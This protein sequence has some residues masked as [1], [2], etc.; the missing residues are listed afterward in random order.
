MVTIEPPP[1]AFRSGSA[2]RAVATS[3]YALTS[4][5]SQKRSRG[6]SVKRPSRSSAA[7]KATEWTRRSSA[8]SNVSATSP[9][10]RATSA[11][12]RTS[13]AV[14]SG[15]DTESASS[16]TDFSIRSP[17]KVNARVAPSSA[18]R[19]AIPHAIER[20][21][22][23]PSTSPRL[24]AKR[25]STSKTLCGRRMRQLPCLSLLRPVLLVLA[26]A[27]A[28]AAA[29][30][31]AAEL[32]PSRYPA[33]APRVRTGRIAIPAAGASGRVEVLVRLPQAPLARW[34]DRTLQ[35]L[36]ARRSKLA[37]RSASS[38]AYIRRLAAAQAAATAQ[39]RQAIPG[40]RVERRF[41]IVLNALAVEL[42]ASR[43]PSLLRLPFVAQVYPSIQYRPTL[44]TSPAIIGATAL[45]AG[46]TLGDGIKIAV[47]DDGIDRG[48]RFFDPSGFAYP[49][50]FPKGNTA[51]TTPKVIVARVFFSRRSGRRDRLPY[52]PSVSF[53]GTHVAGI[54]AGDAGTTAPAGGDHPTVVGLSGVAP[55]ASVGNYRVFTEPTPVGHVGN[56]PQIVAAFEAAV[57]DGM[58]VINFSGGGA[59][60]DPSRDALVTTVNNVAAAGVVPVIAA[61]NDRTDFGLGTVGSPSTADAAISVAA[62]SNT[63]VFGSALQA[64]G[65]DAPPELQ[66]IP[67]QPGVGDNIT[68]GGFE[69]TLV[70]V[71]SI[72]GTDGQPVDPRLCGPPSD[73]NGGRGTIPS[74]SLSGSILLASRGVCTFAS[75]GERASAAGADGLNLMDNRPGEPNVFPFP[76]ASPAAISSDREG[77]H[78]HAFLAAHGGRAT[79][80]L[81]S[82]PRQVDTGR[83]GIITDFSSGGPTP[84]GHRLKP[85][86]A[87]PGGQ[88]LSST[89]PAGGGPFAVFDG[90][91]M[92]TPHVAGAA[93]LLLERHPTW[94]PA[95]IKSALVAT[96]G[97]A[98][99]NTAR[100]VEAPVLLEGSG[101]V[102]LMTADTPLV[103]TAPT[104]LSFAD[105]DASSGA[106]ERSQLVTVTD[107]GGGEGAWQ[108]SV[109]PQAATAGT[110]VDATP[111]VQVAPGGATQVSVAVHVAANAEK[112][113]NYGFVLLSRGGAMRRIPYLVIVTRPA[114]A[115]V[116]AK[117][118][119]RLQRGDTRSGVS[120]ASFYRYPTA[121][122]GP[123]PDYFGPP[124]VEDGA[125]QLYVKRVSSKLVNFGAV[126]TPLSNTSLP[127]PWVL[128]SRDEF[129]VQ[130]YTGTPVNVNSLTLLY[131]ADIGAAG[132]N[133]PARK[134]YY[135]VVDSG[136]DDFT[137]KSLAG[138]YELRSWVNDVRRPTVVPLTTR[139]A[140]GRPTLAARVVDPG[141]GSGIDPFSL[142]VSYSGTLIGAA[143]YDPGSHL[144]V[145]PLPAGV[146]LIRRGKTATTWIAADFQEAKNLD[147]PAIL[148]NTRYRR[149]TIR[150]VNGPA[151]TWLTPGPGA[152]VR[153]GTRLLVLASSTAR[154]RS[155]RFLDEQR[156]VAVDRSGPAN[157]YVVRWKA[158]SPHRTHVLRAVVLDA[159]GR[160][161]EARLRARA[162]S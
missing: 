124:V 37:V 77:G 99:A 78:L 116:A 44:N 65:A 103:F 11:S 106:Q 85:D 69:R 22:A 80:R 1:A 79:V 107:A 27:A 24:P 56:T 148:P 154:I 88:I 127:H 33:D 72:V 26:T 57:R 156:T 147:T 16:R 32:R 35:V 149:G 7:A 45:E 70:D 93:A 160:R 47:I 130:G 55:H 161:A 145:F 17:W 76:V 95:Q 113:E 120:R 38:Q 15:L 162:C 109:Q 150:G 158:G 29:L 9:K 21:L 3:E 86:V 123:A 74:G 43:L 68:S 101:L 81:L 5:A 8:P 136:R 132:A 133:Y 105:V 73:V 138:R 71:S 91:S 49:A 112:G 121:P 135:V 39:L 140:A 58:D 31:A 111:L 115:G 139:V 84:F 6:V 12:A 114:F 122:F 53:H 63:H 108:V 14:T 60:T 118:L 10:T 40:A 82:G 87:A 119:K 64:L 90:T 146:P 4:S 83:S 50:G 51:Y 94:T 18:R 20:R 137:G 75:K 131:R 110:Q 143:A 89:T 66:S 62:A 46:G 100:T 141:R 98:W 61:G 117:A 159:R 36:G 23:T 152:C 30:P 59:Q 134:D 102:N 155:V 34:Q 142:V 151:V 54:A 52:D 25:P 48:H 92:A 28:L 125:E 19:R 96:A 13:H 153:K 129:D 97:P 144:A 104:S 128:G 67:L 126:A 2:A 41:Q 42:P 157:I